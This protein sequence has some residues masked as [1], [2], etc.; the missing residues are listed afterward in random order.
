MG[1]HRCSRSNLVHPGRRNASRT[2]HL[3]GGGY[4]IESVYWTF[5]LASEIEFS[6]RQPFLLDNASDHEL[7]NR[8]RLFR[9]HGL[10][11]LNL[12]VA[13]GERGC[14]DTAG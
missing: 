10:V 5:S 1:H 6:L 2:L 13:Q 11:L 12:L 7:A 4:G 3:R 9:V 8:R 14:R